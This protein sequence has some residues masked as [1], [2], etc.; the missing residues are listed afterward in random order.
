MEYALRGQSL[1][2]KTE[3]EKGG[4]MP[5]FLKKKTFIFRKMKSATQAKS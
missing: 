5:E 1:I 3:A 4:T 2:P